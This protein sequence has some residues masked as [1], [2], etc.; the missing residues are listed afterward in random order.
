MVFY[1]DKM[2]SQLRSDVRG[3]TGD[4]TFVHLVEPEHTCGKCRVVARIDIPAGSSIGDHP[5][6]PDAEIY[7]IISGT[8]TVTDNGQ[9]FTLNPG[10]AMFTGDGNHHSIANNTDQPLSLYAVVIN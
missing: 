10:D 7:I 4:M 3:G 1:S 2:R 5:H 9:T 6:G 8:A